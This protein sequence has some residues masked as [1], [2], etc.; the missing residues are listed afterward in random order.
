MRPQ[1]ALRDLDRAFRNFWRERK[2]GRKVGFPKFKKKGKDDSFRLTGSIRVFPR[3][4]QLPRLGKIRTKEPT[5]KLEGRILSA[6]V[7]READRWYVSLAVERGRGTPQEVEGPV[8][9]VDLGLDCLAMLSDGSKIKSPKP[10]ASQ[11]KLLKKRSKQHSRKQDG[12]NNRRKSAIK[13][14]RLYRRIRLVRT[15]AIHKF[16]TMLTKTKS[17]IVIE[18][19][20]VGN[21]MRNW[22]LARN[23]ADA[24]WY[25]V[26]RQLG[27]KT[28]W[29]GSKLVVAPRKFPSTRSCSGCG[30]IGPRLSLS[31]RIFRCGVCGLVLDR[32]LNAAKNLERWYRKFSGNQ[33]A[34]GESSFGGTIFRDRSTRNDSP[35]AGSKRHSPFG[36]RWVSF[37]ERK[38]AKLRRL[39]SV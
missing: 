23:I 36:D 35:Q 26:R 11:L 8:V 20:A 9:G 32:D 38:R 4:V 28:M 19:L 15:D 37:A 34:C 30:S 12:S 27:Y 10:L 5:T 21:M 22:R 1:E 39:K 17:V 7:K 31:C 16:T 3:H 6:T 33:Y 14:S 25:E 18:N 29:N 24:G 2:K 13:L